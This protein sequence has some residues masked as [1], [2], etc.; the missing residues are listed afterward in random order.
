MQRNQSRLKENKITQ[1]VL[2]GIFSFSVV[3]ALMDS[4]HIQ[5]NVTSLS[6]YLLVLIVIA[7]IYKPVRLK[8][9]KSVLFLFRFLYTQVKSFALLLFRLF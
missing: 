4:V 7:T 5:P 2:L 9:I 6:F 1:L 8:I 3:V